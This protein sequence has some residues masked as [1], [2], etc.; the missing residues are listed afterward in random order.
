[1]PLKPG[2]S[3]RSSVL[4]DT[5]SPAIGN[6]QNPTKLDEKAE[7]ETRSV[8][9]ENHNGKTSFPEPGPNQTKPKKKS[10]WDRTIGKIWN[11]IKSKLQKNKKP[12]VQQE[13]QPF[14]SQPPSRTSSMGSLDD[15]SVPTTVKPEA[16]PQRVLQDRPQE[17]IRPESVVNDEPSEPVTDESS[18]VSS[19]IFEPASRHS[20]MSLDPEKMMAGLDD[21]SVSTA[22]SPDTE[23]PRSEIIIEP[24]PEPEETTSVVNQEV[25]VPVSVSV[26]G[27]TVDIPPPSPPPPPAPPPPPPPAPP[28]PPP[29]GDFNAF[30]EKQKEQQKTVVSGNPGSV[31]QQKSG[32]GFSVPEGFKQ[33]GDLLAAI[34][35]PNRKALRPLEDRISKESAKPDTSTYPLKFNEEGVNRA[36][37]SIDEDNESISVIEGSTDEDW[38]EEEQSHLLQQ[39]ANDEE[40]AKKLETEAKQ[41]KEQAKK[42]EIEAKE[43]REQAQKDAEEKARLREIEDLRPELEKLNLPQRPVYPERKTEVQDTGEE[44]MQDLLA[45][46]LGQRRKGMKGKKDQNFDENNDDGDW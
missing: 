22:N 32:S 40:R 20:S 42:L 39:K 17:Q 30:L 3:S 34:S 44:S 21:I 28:P 37:S 35:D 15:L 9:V 31:Q 2:D 6:G 43:K 41:K 8:S 16:T 29:A 4:L 12:E 13:Y 45:K 11:W 14:F 27:N 33:P 36:I 25:T 1:M 10:L 18:T 24:A 26:D 19:D 7:W 38:E 5:S 46:S 23:T